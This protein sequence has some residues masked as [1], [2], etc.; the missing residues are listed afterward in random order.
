MIDTPPRIRESEAAC[1]QSRANGL[2]PPSLLASIVGAPIWTVDHHQLSSGLLLAMEDI[3][4]KTSFS[5]KPLLCT[6]YV[7][8]HKLFFQALDSTVEYV[9]CFICVLKFS[10][11]CELHIWSNVFV[12]QMVK[13]L[14][15][16]VNST[17]LLRS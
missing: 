14:S 5:P 6:W 3:V 1:V 8:C 2:I 9:I 10:F 13:N 16:A 7:F 4:S 12:A 11:N 15:S 17:V